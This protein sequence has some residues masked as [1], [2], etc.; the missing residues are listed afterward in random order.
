V[1]P[2]AQ[3]VAFSTRARQ[4]FREQAQAAFTNN[5]R[6]QPPTRARQQFP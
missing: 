4:Q 3:R 1:E 6:E 2:G 5:S